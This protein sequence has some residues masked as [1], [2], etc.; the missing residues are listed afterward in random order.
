M[1]STTGTAFLG[2]DYEKLGFR[3][4]GANQRLTFVNHRVIQDIL[5]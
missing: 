3:F 2:L 4:N 5:A 1:V